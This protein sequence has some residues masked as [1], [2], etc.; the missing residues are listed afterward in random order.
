MVK[1]EDV[2]IPEKDKYGGK[3]GKGISLEEF[4]RNTFSKMRSMFGEKYG[5]LLCGRTNYCVC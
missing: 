4:D 2:T 1:I 5:R 3:S